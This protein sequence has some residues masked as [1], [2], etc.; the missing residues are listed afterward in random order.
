MLNSSVMSKGIF[1]IPK[2]IMNWLIVSADSE[3]EG[4][5]NLLPNDHEV[6]SDVFQEEFHNYDRDRQRRIDK[7]KPGSQSIMEKY[8][9]STEAPTRDTDAEVCSW[10]FK[11]HIKLSALGYRSQLLRQKWDNLLVCA[12]F[13]SVWLISDEI[14]WSAWVQMGFKGYCAFW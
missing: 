12:A 8:L 4:D 7:T 14:D 1:I 5:S 11:R 10:F 2:S 3:N 13:M 9:M 6:L